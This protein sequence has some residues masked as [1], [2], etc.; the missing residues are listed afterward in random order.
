MIPEPA[1]TDG[2]VPKPWPLSVTGVV[3]PIGPFA[4]GE[5]LVMRGVTLPGALGATGALG[6][7][8]PEQSW[9]V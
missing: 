5:M 7:E 3:A 6:Q 1:S 9:P 8:P 4:G 2:L